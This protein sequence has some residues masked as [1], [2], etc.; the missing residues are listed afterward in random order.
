MTE[1]DS[2]ITISLSQQACMERA[3]AH[4]SEG[5][6]SHFQN[7][8]GR[9]LPIAEWKGLTLNADGD[10]IKIKWD[11]LFMEEGSID[12]AWLPPT[13]EMFSAT[14]C[15][16]VGPLYFGQLPYSM[17][18]FSVRDN[19]LSGNIHFDSLPIQMASL[20]L[21]KNAFHGN[22][23]MT[24]LPPSM[25]YLYLDDNHFGGHLDL[26]KLPRTMYGLDLDRNKFHSDIVIGK[27]P[28]DMRA[29]SLSGNGI[30]EEEILK[31]SIDEDV[32]IWKNE[33]GESFLKGKLGNDMASW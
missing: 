12:F 26:T 3:I 5:D 23:D 10:I 31:L 33:C 2:H 19:K 29:I 14:H 16:L 18:I 13:V 1:F 15:S 9:F 25:R 32:R 30:Q 4:L 27:L 20:D 28:V 22:L 17:R 8:I 6:K 7:S 11:S 21:G 24:N